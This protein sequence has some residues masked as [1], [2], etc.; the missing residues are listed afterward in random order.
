MFPPASTLLLWVELEEILP[1]DLL[2]NN[3]MIVVFYMH[4][5]YTLLAK[6]G[7]KNSA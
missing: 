6:E 2:Y 1:V 3:W 7:L 5:V 4:L